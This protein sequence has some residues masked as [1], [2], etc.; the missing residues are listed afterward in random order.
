M[1]EYIVREGT[2]LSVDPASVVVRIDKEEECGGCRSCAV[3]S[4][5]H[6][7]E[8]SHIDISV[9]PLDGVDNSPGER[10]RIAYR[11]ANPAVASIIMFV[12]S[13][14]G[15]FLGG[16]AA[17]RIWGES[18]GLFLAGCFGGLIVGLGLTLALSRI[19]SLRPVAR[20]LSQ[21]DP[22]A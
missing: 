5:C 22:V 16:F 21:S 6:G 14:V 20:L 15:L 8:S 11:G 9:Q 2:V 4:V 17:N 12:P 13:L 10:V 19:H 18:D 1:E 7:R 3:R